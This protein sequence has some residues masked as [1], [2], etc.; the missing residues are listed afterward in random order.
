MVDEVQSVGEEGGGE[1]EQR[2]EQTDPLLPPQDNNTKFI[3]T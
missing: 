2:S 3:Q 1:V